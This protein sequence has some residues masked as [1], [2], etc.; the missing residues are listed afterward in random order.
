MRYLQ[1]IKTILKMNWVQFVKFN[2]LTSAVTRKKGVYIIPYRGARVQISP[3]SKVYLNANLI[4]N[5]S[6]LSQGESYLL[7]DEGA[8]LKILDSFTVYYNCDIAVYKNAVLTLGGGYINAGSQLRCSKAITI[9]KEATIARDVMVIDSDSHQ[10]CDGKHVV[11]QPIVIGDHVWLGTRSL[12]LKG[13]RIDDGA[14]VAAGS[15]VTK[16]VGSRCIVAGAPAKCVR[17][18]VDWK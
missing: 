11:D 13:V 4:L 9:G 17:E 12:V 7:I 16:D 14:I 2:F 5:F 10:I 15:I 6:P 18:N 8:E 3:G 1:R